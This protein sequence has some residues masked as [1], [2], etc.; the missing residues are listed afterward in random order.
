M[1]NRSNLREQCLK[2]VMAV[3][4]E[5]S[6]LQYKNMVTKL[7]SAILTSGIAQTLA[8][9]DAVNSTGSEESEER[10]ALQAV[11]QQV[12]D[13]LTT[14]GFLFSKNKATALDKLLELAL[15]VHQEDYRLLTKQALRAL[16]YLKLYAVS[17]SLEVNSDAEVKPIRRK[18]DEAETVR[19]A[20]KSVIE[21]T[22]SAHFGLHLEKGFL[23]NPEQNKSQ[24]IAAGL[25]TQS[26]AGVHRQAYEQ[27]YGRWK[28]GFDNQSFVSIP[29]KTRLMVGGPSGNALET[30]VA[31]HHVYG[32]PMIPGSAIKGIVRLYLSES[33]Y[34]QSLIESMLGSSDLGRDSEKVAGCVGFYDAWWVPDSATNPYQLDVI[35]THHKEYYESQGEQAGATDFDTPTPIAQISVGGAFLFAVESGDEVWRRFALETLQYALE[36]RGI[37][38]KTS[39]GYGYFGISEVLQHKRLQEEAFKELQ[40]QQAANPLRLV[41]ARLAAGGVKK[42]TCTFTDQDDGAVKLATST[43][44]EYSRLMSMLDETSKNRLNKGKSLKLLVRITALGGKN[45]GISES[46]L[47]VEDAK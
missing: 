30:S 11:C 34:S 16:V 7:P 6:F 3:K 38:A 21:V 2:K 45:F 47:H 24:F 4:D 33:G 41:E 29:L 13:L 28:K 44:E 23:A 26:F 12:L 17:V 32:F 20:L 40:A 8:G 35:T 39:N 10:K 31:T 36:S 25:N 9:L 46:V 43:P 18:F 42:L 27:A 22:D 37:G 15:S 19:R 14:Q 1:E 5:T